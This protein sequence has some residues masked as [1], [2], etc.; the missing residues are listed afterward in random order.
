ME[1]TNFQPIFD[2]IDQSKK[3]LKEELKLDLATK[4]DINALQTSVDKLASRFDKFDTESTVTKHR[5]E[6]VEHWV[7]KAAEKIEVPYNP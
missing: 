3:E 6:R 5:V 7:T 2:Y 1:N 4:A